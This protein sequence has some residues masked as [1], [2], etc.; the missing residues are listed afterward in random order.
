[1]AILDLRWFDSRER[2]DPLRNSF[3]PTAKRTSATAHSTSVRYGSFVL[4]QTESLRART[5]P[6]AL[7]K[8]LRVT[9][10]K[11]FPCDFFR[12]SSVLSSIVLARYVCFQ[13]FEWNSICKEKKASS[14]QFTAVNIFFKIRWCVFY[15]KE[16]FSGY[17]SS[18]Q[19]QHP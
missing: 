18:Y 2:G 3:P 8:S 17:L 6:A 13:G 15:H 9:Q 1:M 7:I 10:S 14:E 4:F 19:E 11:L 12:F 16:L 5:A